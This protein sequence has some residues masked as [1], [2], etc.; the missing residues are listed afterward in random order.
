MMNEKSFG[1]RGGERGPKIFMTDDDS[2]EKGALRLVWPEA[3][4]K[5]CTFHVLQV[6]WE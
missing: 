6:H 3:D 2:A 1:G 4:Q 5:L